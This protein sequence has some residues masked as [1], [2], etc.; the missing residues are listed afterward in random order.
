[1]RAQDI[2]IY[3][4]IYSHFLPGHALNEVLLLRETRQYH[5]HRVQ[6]FSK[7]AANHSSYSSNLFQKLSSISSYLRDLKSILSSFSTKKQKKTK[8]FACAFCTFQKPLPALIP[9]FLTSVRSS[10]ECPSLGQKL[11]HTR[12]KRVSICKPQAMLGRA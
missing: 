2:Y 7:K 4:K 1:M 3:I 10:F 9:N 12:G 6:V 8:L 11:G 5:V